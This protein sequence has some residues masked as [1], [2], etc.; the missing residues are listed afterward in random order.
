M[1]L[2]EKEAKIARTDKG[3]PEKLQGCVVRSEMKAQITFVAS[4]FYPSLR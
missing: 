2:E 1:A 4:T 3:T